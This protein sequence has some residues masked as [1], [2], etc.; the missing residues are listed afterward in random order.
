MTASEKGAAYL[1]MKPRTE[2][3]VREYLNKKGF[4][5]EEICEA[6][7]ELKEYR[8][9]DDAEFSRLYIRYGIAKGR[10]YDRIRRELSSKGVDAYTIEDVFYEMESEGE[11]EDQ[12]DLAKQIAE[13]VLGDVDL[14]A[15]SY[16]ERRKMEGRIG[17]RLSS[18]GFPHETIYRVIGELRNR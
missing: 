1:A 4:E 15:V 8:Y 13:Q 3:E 16:D 7:A 5:E 12:F 11:L 14:G 18:R 9:L 6:V 2:K 17:R 10:G